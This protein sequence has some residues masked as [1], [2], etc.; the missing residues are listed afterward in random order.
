MAE[1]AGK[2]SALEAEIEGYNAGFAGCAPEERQMYAGLINSRTAT[3]TA[4]IN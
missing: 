1:L 3:L 4:L 2:I